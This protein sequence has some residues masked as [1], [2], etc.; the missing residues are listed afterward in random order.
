M[1]KVTVEIPDDLQASLD[2]ISRDRQRPTEDILRDMIER[3][4]ALDQFRKLRLELRPY[5]EAAGVKTDD[6]VFKAVS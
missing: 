5:A 1:G 4:V 6:D 3:A 2:A